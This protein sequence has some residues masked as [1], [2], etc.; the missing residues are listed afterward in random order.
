MNGVGGSANAAGASTA[1]VGKT[2][3]MIKRDSHKDYLYG[4]DEAVIAE[5]MPIVPSPAMIMSMAPNG[6]YLPTMAAGVVAGPT[7]MPIH[8]H[9]DPT[10]AHAVA[11]Y[12]VSP[13]HI[14]PVAFIPTPAGNYSELT[15]KYTFKSYYMKVFR[16]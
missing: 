12:Y 13:T 2:N 5:E 4:M 3:N 10:Q 11:A 16:K 8:N 6:V 7:V 9:Q 14:D 15:Q 1:G